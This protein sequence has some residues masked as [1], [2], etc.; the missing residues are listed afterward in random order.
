MS[1]RKRRARRPRAYR[2][3]VETYLIVLG[4]VFALSV[5]ISLLN[6]P[7]ELDYNVPH[8]FG[9]RDPTFLPSVQATEVPTVVRGNRVSILANGA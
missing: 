7:K 5:A 2:I 3:P 9:V 4:G 1:A 6:R 8:A